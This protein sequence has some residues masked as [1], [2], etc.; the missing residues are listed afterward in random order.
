MR[1]SFELSTQKNAWLASAFT[2]ASCGCLALYD[3]TTQYCTSA[4]QQVL[5]SVAVPDIAGRASIGALPQ[6]AEA[7]ERIPGF[8]SL[9]AQK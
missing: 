3:C 4:D 6:S 9:C 5:N 2:D 1:N 7:T 8:Q